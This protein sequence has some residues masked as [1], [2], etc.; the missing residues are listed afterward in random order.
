[1][2]MV[3]GM[4]SCARPLLAVLR[5]L[6]E[7][8]D[9]LRS[10]PGLQPSLSQQQQQLGAAAGAGGQGGVGGGAP[11][12]AEVG[13]WWWDEQ[14]V[15]AHRRAQSIHANR[16]G[17]GSGGGNGSGFRLQSATGAAAATGPSLASAE[18]RLPMWAPG[19]RARG[20]PAHP[21][22]GGG[23]AGGGGAGGGSPAA[24]ASGA[25]GR[26]DAAG[27]RQFPGAPPS[28][29]SPFGAGAR[30]SPQQGHA[31]TSA[32]GGD[33]GGGGTGTGAPHGGGRMGDDVVG[34]ASAASAVGGGVWAVAVRDAVAAAQTA[35]LLAE[36]TE[37]VVWSEF[38]ARNAPML[39]GASPCV[40]VCYFKILL[41]NATCHDTLGTVD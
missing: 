20:S 14:L 35:F 39:Y 12:Q 15:Q 24:A 9:H 28:W 29:Y 27:G 3:P 32:R 36:D 11:Q 33:G 38:G 21:Q 40:S 30:G 31:P 5:Q 22:G 6:N 26:L 37:R 16:G 41:R 18:D 13:E 4:V 25:P 34:A 1:M 8:A 19:G 17:G 7:A 2:N 23:S 10:P